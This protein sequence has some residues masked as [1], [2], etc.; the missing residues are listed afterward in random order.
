MEKKKADSILTLSIATAILC[1]IWAWAAGALN[2][3]GWAGFAGC[4]TYFASGEHGLKGL[5]KT[6]A[7]N[8]AG[9][10]CGAAIL[11]LST[12]MPVLGEL[13]VWCAI[14]TFVMCILSKTKLLSFC[15]GTFVGC[16]STFAAD[17]RWVGLVLS[18]LIGALLG[19]ACDF[20]GK[21]LKKALDKVRDKA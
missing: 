16:F 3:I 13:G 17:G 10:L 21:G 7:T 9:V 2:L 15:P 5:I 8:M 1:G 18:L 4:T 6:G 12:V 20:G 11:A 14:L 19:L